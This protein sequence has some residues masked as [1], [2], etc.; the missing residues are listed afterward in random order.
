CINRLLTTERQSAQLPAFRAGR[1]LHILIRYEQD[2][3]DYLDYEIRSYKRAFSKLGRA[4]K[5][6]K[7]VFNTITTDPKRRG[8]AWKEA[9]RKKIAAKQRTI[10]AE[11]REMQ[12]LKYFDFGN[13]AIRKYQ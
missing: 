8:N 6:E 5:T 11:K 12:L 1:L 3:L 7:L 10:Q 4:N 9:A 2:D 13:W